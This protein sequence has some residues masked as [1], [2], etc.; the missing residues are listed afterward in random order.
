MLSANE[1]SQ[2]K[3]ALLEEEARLLRDL[4][5]IAEEDP[6]NPGTYIPK[7]LETGSNSDDDNAIES[8]ALAD[9]LPVV[10]RLQ[11]ELRDVRKA[12]ASLERGTYGICKYCQKPIDIKRLEAR[13]TSSSCVSCK[14]TLTHEL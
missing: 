11:E 13:P 6:T 9:D 12:L 14:K 1:L 5:E 10:E 8:A 7:H 3:Q 4:G 2:Q